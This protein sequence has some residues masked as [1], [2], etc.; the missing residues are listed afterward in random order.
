[1]LPIPAPVATLTPMQ[2]SVPLNV[3]KTL[4]KARRLVSSLR[5]QP[6]S[7]LQFGPRMQIVEDPRPR[8]HAI[9]V[10]V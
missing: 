7:S 3:G 1:M 6:G 4:T 8:E 2:S 9:H 10:V 5:R